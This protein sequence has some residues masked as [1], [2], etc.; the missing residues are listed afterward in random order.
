M[1]TPNTFKQSNVFVAYSPVWA[2]QGEIG[3]A[4][5][6]DL[7]TARLP[8]ARDARPLPTRRVTRDETRDCTGRY[9]V[10]RR[11][12]SR[13]ALWTLQFPDVT[14]RLTAGLYAMAYGAAGAVTGSSAPYT[15]PITRLASD[16]LPA[17]TFVVGAEDSDEPFEVYR[18]MV[19]NS[20]ELRAEVRQKLSL[21][22]NFIGSAD[23]ETLE[24]FDVPTCGPVPVALYPQDRLLTIGGTNYTDNLRSLSHT[25]NNNVYSN[26]DP[27]VWDGID[28]A[29]LERGLETA[30]F[31]FAL[32]GT[33]AH[34]L[35]AQALAENILALSLR[36]GTNTEGATLSSPGAQVTLGDTPVG[37]AGEA[38]RSVINLVADPFSVSG[39]IPDSVTY[40]GGQNGR[41]LVVPA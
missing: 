15:E 39:A 2:A 26:D 36:L 22:A 7:L 6:T 23:V 24:E 20:L 34:P 8:L 31:Q 9:L 4:L 17:T 14:A 27:F 25:Y 19:L 10:G 16:K 38:S 35:Y 12:T 28:V 1:T 5:D 13:L 30:Q 18:D 41:L 29:R 33:K 11:I 21:T 37:Y 3:T 40:V 32:Y